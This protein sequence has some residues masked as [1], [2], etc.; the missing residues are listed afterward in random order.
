VLI[1]GFVAY[2]L[3]GTIKPKLLNFGPKEADLRLDFPS[4]RANHGDALLTE[5]FAI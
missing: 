5:V 1:S 3:L 2:D 4:A